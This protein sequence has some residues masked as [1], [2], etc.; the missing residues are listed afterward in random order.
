MI[1]WLVLA[2]TIAEVVGISVGVI[3]AGN[4][5]LRLISAKQDSAKG[6]VCVVQEVQYSKKLFIG[7]STDPHQWLSRLSKTI[8]GTLAPI[9]V[10]PTKD[11]RT[12]EK[13]LKRIYAPT[14]FEDAW[15][16]LDETQVTELLQLQ[17]VVDQ[18][19]GN[20]INPSVELT[21]EDLERAKRL[22]QLLSN[23]TEGTEIQLDQ[24]SK[25][26]APLELNLKSVP[27]VNY[28]TL[29]TRKRRSGYLVVVRDVESNLYKIASTGNLAQYIDKALSKVSLLF[30]LELVM[31]LES[32]NVYD[33]EKNLSILYPARDKNGWLSLSPAQLQEIRNLGSSDV[34]HAITFVTPKTHWGL[35]CLP[36]R[37]YRKYT[38]LQEPAGYVCIVQGAKRGQQY[39][40]W[41]TDQLKD[42]G[43]LFGMP[44]Q[45]N[46]P[47]DALYSPEPVKFK[48]II[49]SEYAKPFEAFLKKRYARFKSKGD[50]F[51]LDDWYKLENAQL[52]EIRKLGI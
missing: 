17:I 7:R 33:V 47:H 44:G 3:Q 51:K 28:R 9:L 20:K 25:S 36:A 11:S 37:A 1:E 34:V 10:I 50:L 49:R 5:I 12:L 32:S 29:A 43:G 18:A 22:Y 21:S 40:I 42:S 2:K 8:P 31:A 13:A 35:E 39:K 6:F 27:I 38:Q 4:E 16:N 24:D 52:D 19:V 41:R 45:L 46:N 14:G 23:A 26:D 48:C 30:G 15:F